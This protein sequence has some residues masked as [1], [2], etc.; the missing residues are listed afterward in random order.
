MSGKNNFLLTF[1][2]F[3][4]GMEPRASYMLGKLSFF[5]KRHIYLNNVYVFFICVWVCAYEYGP[6]FVIPAGPWGSLVSLTDELQS[7]KRSYLK[8]VG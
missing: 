3:S 4:L 5:L 8:E 6:V 1:F 2:S 7:N